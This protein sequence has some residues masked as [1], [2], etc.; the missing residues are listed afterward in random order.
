MRMLKLL[1]LLASCNAFETEKCFRFSEETSSK[2]IL[3]EEDGAESSIF[4]TEPLKDENPINTDSI[5]S[6]KIGSLTTL[7]SIYRISTD[8]ELLIPSSSV[9]RFLIVHASV[10]LSIK[11]KTIFRLIQNI[12]I[13]LR[14][15]N[16]LDREIMRITKLETDFTATESSPPSF[17]TKSVEEQHD[18]ATAMCLPYVNCFAEHLENLMALKQQSRESYIESIKAFDE[19]LLLYNLPAGLRHLEVL[20]RNKSQHDDTST[21]E[22]SLPL[23]DQTDSEIS[24]HKILDFEK[25]SESPEATHKE[26]TLTDE[27]REQLFTSESSNNI[28]SRTVIRSTQKCNSGAKKCFRFAEETNRKTILIDEDGTESLIF[29]AEPLKAESPIQTD[30]DD[31]FKIGSLATLYYIYKISSDPELLIPTSSVGRLLVIQSSE[32]A[33]K[34]QETIFRLIQD[35]YIKL[36]SYQDLGREIRRFT[37]INAEFADIGSSSDPL[38]TKIFEEYHNTAE[39]MFLPYINRSGKY[40]ADLK[41]QRQQS[42]ESY[43]ES[44]TALDDFL[45]HF[46]LPA[47]LRSKEPLPWNS[48]QQDDEAT[49]KQP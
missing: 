25:H 43:L 46:N 31:S 5:Q 11:Q 44:I 14:S 2:T 47:G 42:R 37:K 27:D 10:L 38:F 4:K 22:Q 6:F 18:T 40:I 32:H 45:L 21:T 16:D 36:K 29:Q 49:I 19:Y 3:I 35:I 24:L 48:S 1:T 8:P 7:N 30:N 12:Y 34:K 39:T 33:P 26:A 17:L 28:E 20:P 9:G 15:Y 13:N 41:R 23:R